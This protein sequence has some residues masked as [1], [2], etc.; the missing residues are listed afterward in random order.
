[1]APMRAWRR[2]HKQLVRLQ[3]FLYDKLRAAEA[4]GRTE[5]SEQVT[6]ELHAFHTRE[7]S[8]AAVKKP[9][10]RSKAAVMAKRAKEREKRKQKRR[11]GKPD[12]PAIRLVEREQV[13]KEEA[14]EEEGSESS[15]S[16]VAWR[17]APKRH[18]DDELSSALA[19]TRPSRTRRP[20]PPPPRAPPPSAPPTTGSSPAATSSSWTT[21]ATSRS[22]T[23]RRT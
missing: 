14:K 7:R 22:S 18:L 10:V 12:Q 16:G 21:K 8:M 13:V 20:L 2:K 11:S 5:D 23:A 17:P 6:A 3:L 4:E 19:E 1:M 9:R 15:S